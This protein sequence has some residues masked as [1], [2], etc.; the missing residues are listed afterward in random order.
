M[1]AISRL[2][3]AAL[4]LTIDGEEH[5]AEV[6]SWELS[7]EE[8]D[9]GTVTFGDA[10][11]AQ[12]KLKVTIIQSLAADSL[13]QKV[14]DSPGKRNVPFKLAPTGDTTPTRDNPVFDGTL[15]FPNLR[16]TLGMEAKAE[17]GTTDLEFILATID[18]KTS[19]EA[20]A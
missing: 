3:G 16:P 14:Y 13:C 5:M 6:S 1:A 10:S 17:D 2:N 12:P 7:E 20:E 18:K 4:S 8:K 19:A 9:Q 11:A 15:H